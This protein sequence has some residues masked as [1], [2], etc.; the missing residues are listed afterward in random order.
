VALTLASAPAACAPRSSAEP[1]SAVV[2]SVQTALQKAFIARDA[3]A[4]ARLFADDAVAI[5]PD[6]TILEGR[7]AIEAGIGELLPGVRAY[8]VTAGRA[9]R[10]DD[11]VYG[12]ATFQLGMGAP[13]EEARPL[14]GHLLLILQRGA[15]G[16]W[17]IVRSGAWS[18]AAEM[19]EMPG[20]G[21]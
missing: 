5:E 9:E 3:P 1:A 16:S 2:D 20:M 21:R 13:G 14:S 4:I 6:G 7:P 17:K 19:P 15:D 11:L 12:Q 8:G 18:A 10:S